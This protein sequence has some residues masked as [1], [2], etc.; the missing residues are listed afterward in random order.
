M[1]STLAKY[2]Q[3]R[4]AL[5]A[6]RSVDEVKGVRDKAEAMQLYAKQAHD[7]ELEQMAAEIKLRAQRAIGELSAALEKQKN[8]AALPTGGKSK[9]EVLADAG[10]S[11]SAANR[12]EKLAA[13]P[14]PVIEEVIAKSREAGKPVSAK[15]IL[16]QVAPRVIV[17]T[18]EKHEDEQPPAPVAADQVHDDIPDLGV[19][20]PLAADASLQQ[21]MDDLDDGDVPDLEEVN[22]KLEAENA[23]LRDEIADLKAETA[24]LGG[25]DQAARIEALTVERDEIRS[26]AASHH[27]DFVRAN[28]KVVDYERLLKRLRRAAGVEKNSEIQGCIVRL[29]GAA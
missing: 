20:G 15:A 28:A 21:F 16:A 12:Y 27:S 17:P 7:T 26:L 6:C 23:R 19:K 1:M 29:V 8:Q 11:T 2:D 18:G 4:Q 14:E 22:R 24:R 5:A 9:G 3:A 25:T 10:I 13:I